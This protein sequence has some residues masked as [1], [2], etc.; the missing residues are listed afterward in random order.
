MLE[1]MW[2]ACFIRILSYGRRGTPKFSV[3]GGGG[4]AGVYS[5]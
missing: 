5:T 3:N 1:C 2:C 4:G